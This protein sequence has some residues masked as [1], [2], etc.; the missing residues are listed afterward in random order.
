M[1]TDDSGLKA[2]RRIILA[3]NP[4]LADRIDSVSNAELRILAKLAIDLSIEVDADSVDVEAMRGMLRELIAD[5]TIT[6][7]K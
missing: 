7:E 1:D 2:L 4:L 5:E 6:D 3:A